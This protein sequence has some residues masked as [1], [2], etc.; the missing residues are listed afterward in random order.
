MWALL[1]P[2][3]GGKALVTILEFLALYLKSL[4]SFGFECYD[5][6][7]ESVERKFAML[8]LT[9]NDSK[10][11]VKVTC[12]ADVSTSRNTYQHSN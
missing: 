6:F 9:T 3:V 7:T 2:S 1:P 11:K 5:A 12:A 8:V 4:S 10:G